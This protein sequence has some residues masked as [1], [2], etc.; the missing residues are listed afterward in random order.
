MSVKSVS[1]SKGLVYGLIASFVL[2]VMPIGEYASAQ[3]TSAQGG[4][5]TGFIFGKNANTPVAGA[6]VKIRNLE[7]QKELASMPTDEDGLYKILGI[8]EGRYIL[9]VSSAAGDFDCDYAVHVKSGELGKLSMALAPGAGAQ[10]TDENAPKKKG[11][12]K[13]VAG[14]ALLVTAVGVAVYLAFFTGKEA[15]PIR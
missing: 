14:R 6:V 15:S 3:A 11:F 7:D 2:L 13:T 5:L 1:K 9:G 12:F 4:S 10:T 8:P